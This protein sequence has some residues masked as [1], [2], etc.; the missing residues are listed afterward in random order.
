MRD[1]DSLLG[2]LFVLVFS[3]GVSLKVMS[4]IIFRPA[5]KVL[6]GSL[7]SVALLLPD[8]DALF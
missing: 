5:G 7:L 1:P 4:W 6:D 2:G 8:S 3:A